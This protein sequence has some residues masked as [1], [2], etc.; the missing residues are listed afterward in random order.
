MVLVD[1]NVLLDVF[2]NDPAWADWSRRALLAQQALHEL[3]IDP[4]SYAELSMGFS[5]RELLDA[6]ISRLRVTVQTTPPAALFLAG[7]AYLDYRRRGGQ[8]AGVLPDFFIGGHAAAM[9]LALV[10]RD[11]ARFRTYFPT[12]NVIAPLQ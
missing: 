8:R 10:T 1:T 7:R 3:A 5:R 9:G 2:E 4:V 6:A 11:A 12:V